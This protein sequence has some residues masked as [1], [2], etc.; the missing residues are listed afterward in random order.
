MNPLRQRIPI[1]AGCAIKTILDL[2]QMFGRS[3]ILRTSP[4]CALLLWIILLLKEMMEIQFKNLFQLEYL[5]NLPALL[6]F[7]HILAQ[8]LFIVQFFQNKL[9]ILM[10]RLLQSI[11]IHNCQYFSKKLKLEI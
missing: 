11:P 3:I 6:I 2:L 5:C 9:I 10:V 8:N 1:Q 7:W 4:C